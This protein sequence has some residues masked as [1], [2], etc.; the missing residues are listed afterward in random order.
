M[1]WWGMLFVLAFVAGGSSQLS[2]QP[3][4]NFKRVINNWPTIELYFSVACNGKPA[5]F[6]DP[7]FFKVF[8]NGLEIG[9]FTLWCPDPQGRCAISVA[10]VFDNSGS[11]SGPGIAGAIAAGNAFVDLMDGVSDEAAVII[12]HS[13][14]AVLQGM[15]ASKS[16]LHTAVNSMGPMGMTAVW[17]G[18]YAGLQELIANGSNQCRAVIAMTDGGDN[19]STRTPAEVISLANRNRIRVFT[20][21][22]GSGIDASLLQA[23]ADQTGGRYYQTPS[24]AEL[25]Q[26]YQEISTIIFQGFQE[27]VIMY[28]AKCM[29]GGLRTVD[30]QLL[31]FCGGNDSKTKTYRALK[32]TSTYVP[33]TIQ[34]GK[35]VARGN[36]TVKIPITLMD[37]VFN[38][39]FHPATFNLVFDEGCSQFQSISTKG[40][41][42]DGVP[43]TVTPFA[44]GLTIATKDKV[45]LNGSGDLFELTFKTSDPDGVDTVCC[46]IKLEDWV[47]EAGCFRPVLKEGEICIV[48][49]QPKVICQLSTP[50]E[51]MWVRGLK[52]YSPNPFTVTMLVSNQ[53]DREARNVRYT[54]AVKKEDLTLVAPTNTSQNGNPRNVEP[55][56]INEARW[57]LLAKR[58]LTGDSVEVCITASFDN[59]PDVTCCRKIWIPPA[60]AVLAC[61]VTAPDIVADRLNMRYNPMP[62]DVTVTVTNEGGRRSDTVF[63]RIVLPAGDLKLAGA[64]APNRNTKKVLPALLNPGQTGGVTFTLSHPITLTAKSYMVGIWVRSSNADSSYCEVEVII[65]PLEAPIL[66]PRC[67][68]PDSLHF[69]E[70]ID[71]Y[72]PNPFA[73]RLE[74][75]NRGGLPAT[76]VS[77]FI[78]LPDGVEFADGSETARKLYNPSTMNEYTGGPIP[79][80]SWNV[81]YTKKLRYD[82]I[83]TFKFVVGGTGPTGLPLDSVETICQVRVPGLAPSFA[84]TLTLPDSLALNAA[85]TGVEPNPF[86]IVYRVFN[87]SKQ[88]AKIM[89][90]VLSMPPDGLTL[91]GTTPNANLSPNLTLAPGD[92]GTFTW[93]VNVANRIT[94]RNVNIMVTA[95]D[96]EGNPVPCAKYLPIANLKTALICDAATTETQLT[97]IPVLQEYT[98]TKWV[99]NYTLT[100]TGGAPISNVKVDLSVF[101]PTTLDLV[102]LD[103]D[104][105]PI[106]GQDNTSLNREFLV[107]FPGMAE[108]AQWGFRLKNYN[109]TGVPQFVNFSVGYGSKETPRIES[110]C[111]AGVLIQ[112]VV[113]PEL[114]CALEAPDTIRFVTDR[115]EPTPFDLKIQI[116]NIGNGPAYNVKGY[117]LQDT[118]FNILPP[119]LREFGQIDAGVTVDFSDTDGYR[120]RVNPRDTDGY[121]TVRVAVIADGIP[122]TYCEIPIYVEREL[123]PRFEMACAATPNMLTFDDQLNDYAPNPFQVSTQAINVGETKADNCQ[124]VFVGP[125]RFTPV[126]ASPI[127][128][129]P[130]GTMQVRDTVVHTWNLRALRRATGG[131]DTLVYQIQGRGGM[132]QRLII[133]E[134]RVPVYVPAA[135][136]AEYQMVCTAP[137]R[138][139]FDNSAGVYVPDP[140][141]F[142][143]TVTNNG[144]AL[145]QGLEMTAMLPP[146]VILAPG[147][148]AT[149][150]VGDV[151]PGASVEITW[152]VRPV[153]IPPDQPA[154]TVT[155]CAEVGDKFGKSSS[156]CS[157]VE[158]PPATKALLDLACQVQFDTLKVDRN[159]GR[160]EANPFTAGI[161]I[162]NA[163]Q[164]PA[165]SVKVLLLPQSQYVKVVNGMPEKFVA[166]RLDPG[167][168]SSLLVWDLYATPRDVAETVE[169]RFLVTAKDMPS[170]V[171]RVWIHI[172]AVLPPVLVCD[173]ESSMK[174]TADTLF[175]DYDF[176]DY[177]DDLK[178]RSV[179][180]RYN[181]FKISTLVR[182]NGV[183]QARGVQA[184]LLPPPGVSFDEGETAQKLVGNGTLAAGQASTLVTWAIK[185]LRSPVDVLTPFRVVITSENAVSRSCNLDVVIKGAPKSAT[186][187]LPS[188][189]VGRYGEKL[190]VPVTIDPTIG[191]EIYRYKLNVRFDPTV[192][193]FVEAI[194]AGTLTGRGWSGVR[195]K[196]LTETADATPDIVRVEDLTT[197]SAL[198]EHNGGILVMLVFEATYGGTNSGKELEHAVTD[199]TFEPVVTAVENGG[200]VRY[201]SSL[202]SPDDGDAGRDVFLGYVNGKATVSGECI[203]PL[204]ATGGFVLKQ[205]QPNP[206][207]PSTRITY[208]IGADC[209]VRLTVFDALGR[210][211]KTLV[212]ADQ[213]QGVHAIDFTA[214]GLASGTYLYRIETPFYTHMLRMVLTR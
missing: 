128:A 58:R 111:E 112:P 158:I 86:Q 5:Y 71:A 202:N 180:D 43:V 70:S 119:A 126:D 105:T 143:A 184:T 95:Y 96:D 68:V 65:P 129:V 178:S 168:S 60:D 14:V 76:D 175:F 67:F 135:R 209:H 26:I 204:T 147:E 193:R 196:L 21:G 42:L 45:I 149:K 1:R 89:Q 171:C 78:Y 100:N 69:N 7:T 206:F 117:V 46:P 19:S 110:G 84:C 121:D 10:L 187:T 113:M 40:T 93:T 150:V 199:L 29:D 155:L 177:M 91:D 139:V 123:R 136:S 90:V 172:P 2:A 166:L 85:E 30:L 104:F 47:F 138:L 189:P 74:T 186:V 24:G 44:G 169:L 98:P 73:V 179:T 36:S 108:V 6:T 174:S 125:P 130:G 212:D 22:L 124:L 9:D 191:K 13:S 59:H 23:I 12:F 11:M 33:L 127:Y 185:P 192:V 156:C 200:T 107:L 63:A 49:R 183:A 115:Y 48:P 102:E 146:G 208:E 52:D 197:G 88:T 17:D 154:Q 141:E 94:R 122:A 145:G 116:R 4:L 148:T 35:K 15:T 66:T 159:L 57:E 182:N 64:D 211:I 18:I 55:T 153:A 81:R 167:V 103:P 82:Q 120:L 201:V 34:V 97:Y 137:A 61:Q 72:V 62:F 50:N 101:D 79:A 163:G 27:C 106:G 53:G 132:G 164:S 152:L 87:T 32:D 80:V 131:W 162:T 151:N 51:L 114:V 176:G 37:P 134:C 157:K 142:K 3:N 190:Y 28:Q 161:R 181:V 56:D 31:N 173:L 16:M 213:K 109:T 75:A 133:G 99:L 38:D 205:N 210:P 83:L 203:V 194:S 165:D 160:F 39:L 140:F 77:A 170:Q 25:S 195:A 20:I 8:E 41:L 198:N 92:T 214:E 188:D 118:R 54:I 207:N 144:L